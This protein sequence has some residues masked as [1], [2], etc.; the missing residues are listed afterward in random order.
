MKILFI[1]LEQSG[2]EI[3]KSILNNPFFINHKSSIYTFGL[4]ED[5]LDIKD[6]TN[7]NIR[8]LM[9]VSDI[10][11]NLFYLLKLRKNINRLIKTN[12]FNKVFFIDSFDFTKF[13]LRKFLD[14]KIF[15][16]QI[17]GPSVFIWKKN[18]SKFI[19][20]Y[21]RG[22]FSI[23]EIESKYYKSDIYH[24]IGHPLISKVKLNSNFNGKVKNIGFFL[25]SRHQ[26]ISKNIDI[27]YD[28]INK[29]N[30]NDQ[31]S[32]YFF[33]IPV[34]EGLIKNFFSKLNNAE[35]V[36]NNNNYYEYMSKLDFAFACSGTV[37]LELS[38]SHIPHFIFYKSSLLNFL[39]FKYFV[40]SDFLS[41]INIFNKKLIVN[42][43]VQENFSSQNLYKNFLDLLLGNNLVEY[44]SNMLN[45]LKKSNL[46]SYKPNIIIDYLKKFF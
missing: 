6:L 8:P 35:Y 13:Y 37:H 5:K 29:L 23:F 33:T 4:K 15:Y 27:I 31:Y 20:K 19:N 46:Q 39:I 17:V 30:N 7:I 28:L 25:G 3:L 12:N 44:R 36:L 21:M 38:F 32:Y 34:F 42:E 26:E 43:F 10:I 22:I 11:I 2:K 24:F 40:K 14:K 41:L 18:R 45:S 16:Y 1:T 9:G